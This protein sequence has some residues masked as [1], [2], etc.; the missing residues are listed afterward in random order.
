MVQVHHDVYTAYIWTSCRSKRA[1]LHEVSLHCLSLLGCHPGAKELSSK[2]KS[3]E[4]AKNLLTR[5]RCIIEDMVSGICATVPF[6]LGDVDLAGRFVL[7]GKRM[8]LAVF[9]LLRPLH[10]ARASTN[11]GSEKEA[12][13]RRR[14][15][16]IDSKMGI[17]YMRLM[18][19]KDQEGALEIDLMRREDVPDLSPV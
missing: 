1:H 8:P 11:K 17:R 16:F 2:L 12:W 19:N 4:S 13:T 6:T 5:F 18:A 15:D 7:E 3:L 14:S 9:M 10:V